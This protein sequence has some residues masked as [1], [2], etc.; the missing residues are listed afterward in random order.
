[1]SPWR[2]GRNVPLSL[3]PPRRSWIGTDIDE[4]ERAEARGRIGARCGRDVALGVGGGVDGG[5]L[6]PSEAVVSA[7]PEGKG[8]GAGATGGGARFLTSGPPGELRSGGRAWLG[9]K[10]G[11]GGGG[12]LGGPCGRGD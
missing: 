5:E 11:G 7:G 9:G 12:P 6:S 2:L 1:M 8:P 3:R 4:Y 10:T